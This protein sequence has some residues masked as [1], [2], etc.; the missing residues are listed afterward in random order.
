M[1]SGGAIDGADIRE[2]R[3]EEGV[4]EVCTRDLDSIVLT[5]QEGV[6]D[7]GGPVGWEKGVGGKVVG[8]NVV[9]FIFSPEG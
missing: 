7:E 9:L 4:E 1:K 3:G 6:R 8:D 2:E 5:G